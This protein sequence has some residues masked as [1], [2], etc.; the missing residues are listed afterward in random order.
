MK[1]IIYLFLATL[2]LPSSAQ[3]TG[4]IVY[5]YVGDKFTKKTTLV[6]GEGFYF[7]N[8][9]V[10]STHAFV[11]GSKSLIDIED[12][13]IY[14]QWKNGNKGSKRNPYP[15]NFTTFGNVQVT[16]TVE[17]MG[18]QCKVIEF[19]QPNYSKNPTHHIHYYPLNLQLDEG[20][21]KVPA[22]FGYRDKFF[23]PFG[24]RF[25]PLYMKST[26]STHGRIREIHAIKVEPKKVEKE[27]FFQQIEFEEQETQ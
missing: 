19:D 4:E 23:A 6:L 20:Y 11:S 14:R 21:E 26:S 10:N 12:E 16:D 22:F 13:Q 15:R 8:D 7:Q 5:E 18:Y 27:E 25:V 24:E 2:S 9:D 3:F 1:A 17:Y